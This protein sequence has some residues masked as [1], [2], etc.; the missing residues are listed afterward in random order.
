V[1]D[2]LIDPSTVTHMYKITEHIGCCITG[3]SADGRAKV[4]RARYEAADFKYKYAYEIPVDYLTKRM[5]DIAQVS[6]QVPYMRPFGVTLMF[7]AIDEENGP[8][9]FKSDP[10]GYYIGFKATSAGVKSDEADNWFE[11]KLK[12]KK[13]TNKNVKELGGNES[14]TIQLAISCLQNCL[15]AELKKTDVEIGIVTAENPKFRLL[16]EDQIEQHLSEI[17]DRD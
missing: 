4:Q 2:K 8:Q 10:A 13:D 9:L 12:K 5:A 6:T 7:I 11:K 17:A 14:E 3:M 16:T 15:N 1:P